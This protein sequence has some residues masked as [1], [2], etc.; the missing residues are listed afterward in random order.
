MFNAEE[1]DSW[2]DRHR[3]IY[4]AELRAVGRF[5]SLYGDP[6]LEVGVGTG[7]FAS[8][9]GI[10]YGVDPDE[11]MLAFARRRGIRVVRGY[12]EDLPFPDSFFSMVLVATTLPFFKDARRA[13][14]EVHRVLKDGGGF[15]LA[16]IPRHSHLGRKY[17]EMKR[18]GDERFRNAHFYTLDEVEELVSGLF[19]LRGA[20]STLLGEEVKTEIVEGVR[21]D[22]SFVVLD[23]VKI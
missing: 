4:E 8:P 12:G 20:V 22:S 7:R 23:L 2:Y 13:M 18:R 11:H 5:V 10:E 6:K 16:F 21:E 3:D 14:E 19:K 1:Y 9:L 17:E 15:V